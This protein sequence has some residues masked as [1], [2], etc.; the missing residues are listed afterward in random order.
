MEKIVLITGVFGGIGYA[1]AKVFSENG[2][3]VIGVDRTCKK[4]EGNYIDLFLNKDISIPGDVREVFNI[5]S[6]RYGILHCLV[7]NAAI[8]ISKSIL[9]TAENEWDETYASNI[10][11]IFMGVKY[12]Y[13]LLKKTGGS[14]VNMSSVHAYATSKNISAYASTKGAILAFT[15][16]IALEF[17]DDNIRVNAVLPGAVN[18]N[19]LKSGLSRGHLSGENVD[20]MIDKLGLKHPVK[21]IGQP[22]EIGKTIYFLADSEKSAFITGQA[23]V[24]DGGALAQLSTEV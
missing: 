9:E 13:P 7:N 12:A 5:V 20:V 23:I 11:S 16:S 8:Q 15:R 10:K 14:I 4:D 2:W 6:E 17:A 19:M 22:E 3:K 1:T 21:R 24:V 18:T